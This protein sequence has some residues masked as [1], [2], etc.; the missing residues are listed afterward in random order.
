MVKRYSMAILQ[1]RREDLITQLA[2][3]DYVG[4]AV[5][6]R[7]E[8]FIEEITSGEKETARF[9]QKSL[10][11]TLSGSTKYECAFLLWGATSRNGKSTLAETVA[12][13]LGDYAKTTSP[14][15]FS[16]RPTDGTK[17]TPDTARLKGARFVVIPEPD[18]GLELNAAL[19]KQ[20]TGGDTF[21]GRNL[22]ESPF[23][24]RPEFKPFIN[25]NYLP[26]ITDDTLF[27]SNR[28]IIIPFERHFK[29]SEQDR[30]LKDRFRKPENMSGILNWL[31]EGHKM[32]QAE[33]LVLP[34]KL[35]RCVD[36]YR[37]ETDDLSDFL[38]NAL[39][40]A[41]HAR[42]KTME[43]YQSY[44]SWAKGHALRPVNN[45]IFVGELRKRYDVR[46]DCKLGNVVVGMGLR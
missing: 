9:L 2:P 17:V 43:L 7:W 45:R 33:G 10:G 26:I 27:A 25:T 29:A 21:V 8:K 22:R 30:T 39:I 37:Q 4:G 13:I 41:E 40:E 6:N 11:Y 28:I 15:T 14:Q 44:A 19:L 42:T 23:E 1:H 20:F 18:K 31:I 46:R 34:E 38:L 32:L 12:H 5:C 36:E 35:R 24:Y 3:V 16:N